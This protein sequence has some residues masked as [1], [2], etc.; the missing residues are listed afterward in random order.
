MT[1]E[2]TDESRELLMAFDELPEDDRARILSLVRSLSI[3]HV[4]ERLSKGPLRFARAQGSGMS[5]ISDP[6]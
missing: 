4:V 2:L 6:V 5:S 1:P 3:C